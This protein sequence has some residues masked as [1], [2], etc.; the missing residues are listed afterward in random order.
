MYYI[1]LTIVFIIFYYYLLRS[2]LNNVNYLENLIK[3]NKKK[4][5]DIISSINDI[6]VDPA[7][8][9]KK[10]NINGIIIDQDGTLWYDSEN[11]L[12]GNG[13]F[14]LL[15]QRGIVRNTFPIKNMISKSKESLGTAIWRWKNHKHLAIGS[16][17][18]GTKY[19]LILLERIDLKFH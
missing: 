13:F 7:D 1:Y 5:S 18:P 12:D 19:I 14:H 11:P 8:F 16:R 10:N 17:L 15:D 6:I 3:I 2:Y 4:I 9:G